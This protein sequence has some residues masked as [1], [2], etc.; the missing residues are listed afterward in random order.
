MG[1]LSRAQSQAFFGANRPGLIVNIEAWSSVV[2]FFLLFFV[3]VR[4]AGFRIPVVPFSLRVFT[5]VQGGGQA[6]KERLAIRFS[7]LLRWMPS[8]RLL[9][10]RFGDYPSIKVCAQT[11]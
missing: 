7:V 8:P 3:S 2:F 10:S 6:G 1:G 4:K 5:P 9:P 11:F